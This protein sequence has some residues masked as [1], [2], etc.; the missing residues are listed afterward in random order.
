MCF[1]F[2]SFSQNAGNNTGDAGALKLAEALDL[3]TSLT[4]LNLAC[5][6]LLL[7]FHNHYTGNNIGDDGAIHIFETLFVN[8]SLTS[9]DIQG[10][11]PVFIS[12]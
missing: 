9:L 6:Y 7:S 4:S 5:N 10:N 11:I 1:A 8:S 3:N 2:F 12:F